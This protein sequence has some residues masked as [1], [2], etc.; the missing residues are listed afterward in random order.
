MLIFFV[1][2]LSH[3]MQVF[4]FY[5]FQ[6]MWT[7]SYIVI[8]IIENKWFSTCNSCWCIFG[9]LVPCNPPFTHSP[10]MCTFQFQ[11]MGGT[12]WTFFTKW[13][14]SRN[15]YSMFDVRYV[16]LVTI[17]WIHSVLLWSPLSPLH[18][19]LSIYLST[20]HLSIYNIR[21]EDN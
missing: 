3:V 18:I 14:P 4:H 6:I 16:T 2:R 5:Q 9:N 1:P 11:Q 20:L 19:Y 15:L 21:S 13:W 12:F 7:S 10:F 8:I 17:S